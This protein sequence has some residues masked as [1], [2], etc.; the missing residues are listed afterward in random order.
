MPHII[1]RRV[2]A[3]CVCL[4]RLAGC[5]CVR[6]C[7]LPVQQE[8]YCDRH[9][10]AL[11]ACGENSAAGYVV[12]VLLCYETGLFCWLNCKVC[13]FNWHLANTKQPK[14]NSCPNAFVWISVRVYECKCECELVR[15]PA[16]TIYNRWTTLVAGEF[17]SMWWNSSLLRK[18][19]DAKSILIISQKS[20]CM[21]ILDFGKYQI[22]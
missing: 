1:A 9:R 6:V 2:V 3:V 13:T 12:V 5:A 8:L 21:Q 17:K 16:A 19:V 10:V 18:N 11:C 7:V 4:R 20:Q 22:K 15:L 14:Q